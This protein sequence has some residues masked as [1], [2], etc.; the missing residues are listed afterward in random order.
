MALFDLKTYGTIAGRGDSPYTTLGTVFGMPSC[1]LTLGRDLLSLLPTEALAGIL[2]SSQTSRG[3][4]NSVVE[5]AQAAVRWSTGIVEWN[6]DNGDVTWV[7][8]TSKAGIDNDEG[9]FLSDLANMVGAGLN[10]ANQIYTNVQQGIEDVRAAYAC[11]K[12]YLDYLKYRGG[13]AA[14]QRDFLD[15]EPFADSIKAMYNIDILEVRSAQNFI[16][17]VDNLISDINDIINERLADPTKEPEFKPQFCASLSAAGVRVACPVPTQP[18]ENATSVFRLVFAPPKS[19]D[20]QFLLSKDGLYFNSQ[21][22]SGITP[23]LLEVSAAKENILV[24]NRWKFEHNPNLGGRG[25]GFSTKDLNYYIDTK[26]D[27][28]IVNDSLALRNHYEADGF[29]QDIIAQ[30]N[31]R[32]YDISAQIAELTNN[33]ASEMIIFNLKQSLISENTLFQDRINK[34]KKQIELAVTLPETPLYQLGNVPINDFSYLEGV[35]FI[36]DIKKQKALTFSQVDISGVVLP[37]QTKYVISQKNSRNTNLEHLLI[38]DQADGAIIYD[39]SSVSATDA[40]VL[41]VKNKLTV[42]GLIAMYNFLETNVESPSSTKF[43]LRNS[44]SRSKESYA[45][46]VTD[47]PNKVFFNGLGIPYLQGI[48]KHSQTYPNYPNALGSY[49]KLPD[50]SSFQSLMY[51]NTGATIDF[52]VHVPQLDGMHYGFDDGNVSSLHRLILANENVGTYNSDVKILSEDD[53]VFNN[54]G[55]LFVR[56]MV[57]GFTR[58]RRITMGQKPSNNTYDN[59]SENISFFV[60]PTQSISASA[61]SFLSRNYYDNET[62]LYGSG[63]HCAAQSIW[64]TKDGKGFSSCGKE[65]CHIAVTFDPAED[66]IKF[67]LDGTLMNTSAMS[68]VFAIAK[69]DMPRVPTYKHS[70]SFEYNSSNVGYLAPASL[71][72]GPKLDTY[73]TPWIVGG[74]Y[75]DGMYN[76]GN[77]MGGSYGGIISGLRGHI[78]SLKFY[79]KVLNSEEILNNYEAQKNFFKNIDMPNL[80]WEPVVTI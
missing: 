41:D 75:T 47:S 77:F 20:G 36:V 61:V 5:A 54:F 35:D 40:V 15:P 8:D 59:P 73:T 24:G 25:K 28:N 42:D 67:Y 49:I 4:A 68:N 79:K 10:A 71:K 6:A 33:N 26:L 32:I 51:N 76:K 44:G 17:K 31:K 34:R 9:G 38:S 70:N 39:G 60:A 14:D 50:V 53:N 18:Q 58:D 45:Q 64:D 11:L 55:N 63:Y 46:L 13:A 1:L 65:F 43:L 30:K 57:M 3:L 12:G 23:A 52:W 62:C 74:G 2:G 29:L 16:D 7:S 66:Q 48:T 22:V 37:I 27:P 72:F 69:H 56:G 19:K 21:T 78:G 80:M